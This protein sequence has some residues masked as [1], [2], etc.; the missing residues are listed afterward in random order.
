MSMHILKIFK[1]PWI[2]FSLSHF[3]KMISLF[4][5]FIFLI[6][7]IFFLCYSMIPGFWFFF[8]EYFLYIS[9]YIEYFLCILSP[10]KKLYCQYIFSINCYI[11]LCQFILINIYKNPQQQHTVRPILSYIRSNSIFYQDTYILF[12]LFSNNITIFHQPWLRWNVYN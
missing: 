7:V 12:N 2:I 8:F 9:V 10:H 4:Y 11:S 6:L 1:T 3:P 5:S